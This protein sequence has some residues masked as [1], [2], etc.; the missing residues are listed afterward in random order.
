MKRRQL[1]KAFTLVELLIVISIIGVLAAMVMPAVT[2]AM[3]YANKVKSVN[4][5][6]G[7]AQAW[8]QAARGERVRPVG[9][10]S[11]YDW[12]FI[13]AQRADLNLPSMWILDFDPV[14][15]DKIGMGASMPANIGDKIGNIWKIS[16]EFKAFPISWEVANLVSP[17]A[18]GESPLLWSRGLSSNGMWSKDDGVFGDKGGHM[19]FVDMSVKWFDKLRDDSNPRGVLKRY[20]E[21]MPT[22]NI[23]DSIRGGAKNIL[24]SQNM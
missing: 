21:T 13:L 2:G 6:R 14:V 20:D 15:N 11:I 10:E 5:A 16:E 22:F 23:N 1:R 4:N 7:I 19:A 18:P 3:T 8:N 24:K 12:A 9:G 17:N